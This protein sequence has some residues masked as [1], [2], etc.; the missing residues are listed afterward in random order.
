MPSETYEFLMALVRGEE[1]NRWNYPDK[2]IY[3]I[4]PSN[5]SSATKIVITF[6]NDDDFLD[7]IGIEEES[8]DRWAWHRFMSSYS[9]YDSYQYRDD[10]SE[11]YLI[12]NFNEENVALVNNIL[13]Y[14]KPSL[15]LD[16]NDDNST[17]EVSK[18]LETSFENE[19]DNIT[20]EFGTLDWDCKVR[21]IQADIEKETS[22]LFSRFG[23]IE[24]KHAYK[25]ETTVGILI[26][27]YKMLKAEDDDLKDLLKKIDEKYNSHISRGDWYELE[28]NTYCDDFDDDTFQRT[29]EKELEDILETVEEGLLEGGDFEEYNKL[30]DTVLKLGGFNKLIIIPEKNIG[31]VF[32]KIDP[33]TNRLIFK[34]H[35]RDNTV[36]RRSV[37]TLED[38]NLEL[39]HPELFESIRKI[40]KKLL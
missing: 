11:G 18:F 20:Y 5:P 12:K 26:S 13:K 4:Q 25:Y 31:V 9:D 38:L 40:L 15:R 2:L 37:N 3:D 30:Y 35:K 39:Y 19:V 10:W 21:A 22:N 33:E 29:V 27:L 7:V 34:L 16:L 24:I 28:Y 36:E 17:T 6:D 14:T 1:Y 8:N 23:I 32:E